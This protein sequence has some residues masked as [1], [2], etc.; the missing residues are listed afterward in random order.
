VWE[1]AAAVK[2]SP[3][4]VHSES[5]V[6]RGHGLLEPLLARLRARQADRHIPAELRRGRILD[7]GCGTFPYFLS[8]TSFEEKF[9]I[10]RQAPGPSAAP[11]VWHTLDLGAAPRLPFDDG[12]FSAVT[13]LAV[14]EHLDPGSVSALLGEGRRTLAPGGILF[15]TTPAAWANGLLRAMSRVGL[16][17]AEEIDEHQH[18]YTRDL[19]ERC[20]REAGFPPESIRSG[21]FECGL[22]L[23]ALARR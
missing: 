11:I 22:N 23:W 2:P 20:L 21:S 16:V 12:F 18:L 9:A 3:Q 14:V 5:R 10:D 19:L 13:L 8:H 7:V 6:T 15:L 1:D 17:S 4:H